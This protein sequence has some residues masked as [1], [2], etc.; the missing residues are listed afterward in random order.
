MWMIYLQYIVLKPN[1]KYFKIF[2]LKISQNTIET[3]RKSNLTLLGIL[4]N[5]QKNDKFQY[6]NQHLQSDKEIAYTE[7]LKKNGLKKKIKKSIHKQQH[8]KQMINNK[9]ELS[10]G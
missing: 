1:S 6:K 7:G 4:I 2:Q 8:N 10:R 9:Y 5:K 3:R